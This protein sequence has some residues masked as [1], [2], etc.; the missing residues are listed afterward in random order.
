M[1]SLVQIF[2][3]IKNNPSSKTIKSQVHE[4]PTSYFNPYNKSNYK[5]VLSQFAFFSKYLQTAPSGSSIF[6]TVVY[7]ASFH[8]GKSS[9]SALGS[10]ISYCKKSK[11]NCICF[12]VTWKM[13]LSVVASTVS[14]TFGVNTFPW[15]IPGVL[16]Q[17]SAKDWVASSEPCTKICEQMYWKETIIGVFWAL[18]C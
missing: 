10:T 6:G 5:V 14:P 13:W 7:S 1:R 17:Y 4:F 11:T 8:N 3:A 12:L 15:I 16:R 2:I 18:A 9:N